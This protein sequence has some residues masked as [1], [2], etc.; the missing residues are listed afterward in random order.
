MTLVP[1]QA[2]SRPGLIQRAGDYT[3]KR[4]P[5]KG[6]RVFFAANLP[7]SPRVRL[8]YTKLLFLLAL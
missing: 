7:A 2:D 4:P 1:I 3:A 5:R 8:A 6:F